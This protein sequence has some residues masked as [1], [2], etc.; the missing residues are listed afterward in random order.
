MRRV[1]L[2]LACMAALLWTAAPSSATTKLVKIVKNTSTNK[3][4]YSPAIITIV[5]GTAVEWTNTTKVK[6]TVTFTNG[7]T[8]NKTLLPGQSV[9][10]T[11]NVKGTLF[12]HCLIHTYMKG[13][14]TVT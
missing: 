7:A 4:Q 13:K 5:H 1:V 2:A 8:Y 6:H 12:Y 3:F 11:F 14:V 10:R 9:F